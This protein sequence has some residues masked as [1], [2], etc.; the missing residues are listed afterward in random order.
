MRRSVLSTGGCA[1]PCG[2]CTAGSYE[3]A[4]CFKDAHAAV[5]YVLVVDGCRSGR[6][7]LPELLDVP[8]DGGPAEFAMGRHGPG[9]LIFRRPVLSDFE[10]FKHRIE[11]IGQHVASGLPAPS[12]LVRVPVGAE[13]REIAPLRIEVHALTPQNHPQRPEDLVRLHVVNLLLVVSAVG[14]VLAAHKLGERYRCLQRVIARSGPSASRRTTSILIA[15]VRDG[16]QGLAES[17]TSSKKSP[18]LIV[19]ILSAISTRCRERASR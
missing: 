15:V 13:R 19:A 16:P 5:A 9:D 12:A 4:E 14:L 17:R 7:P 10:G 2:Q 1:L 8:V 18:N 3:G 6:E 11:Q